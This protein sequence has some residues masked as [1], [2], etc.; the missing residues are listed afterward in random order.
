MMASPGK[1]AIGIKVVRSDGETISFLRGFG[2]YFGYMLSGV[3]L[4]IGYLMAAFTDRKQA[5]HDMI[6]DTVVVDKWAFTEHPEW[7][8]DTLG[9]VTKIV[10]ALGIVLFVGFFFVMC[11]AI[12]SLGIH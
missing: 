1:L 11:T 7:Q 8:N 12:S 9:T 2:R 5:L 3:I 10:L 4:C 6:C